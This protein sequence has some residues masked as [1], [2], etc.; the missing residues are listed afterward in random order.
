M[1]TYNVTIPC[2]LSVCVTVEAEDEKSAKEAALNVDFR[3]DLQ[4]EDKEASPEIVEF[5]THEQ[6]C[7]GN[8]FYGC[9]NKM[10]IDE[11]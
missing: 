3:L 6:I 10:E 2:T 5:E 9:I 7:R 1:K 8:V 4:S 11:A